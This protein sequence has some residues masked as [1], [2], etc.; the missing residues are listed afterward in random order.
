MHELSIA[1]SFVDGA[2]EELARYPGD[3]VNAVHLKLGKLSGVVKEALLF[4][5]DL[6][7]ER[8]L[9]EGSRLLIEDI[10]PAIFCPHCQT[11]RDASSIQNL[12]CSVCG[13]SSAEIVHGREIMIVGLELENAYETAV[14]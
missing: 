1:M 5:Y 9:L 4:S 11:E 6:A 3:R 2:V 12:V 14:G 7:C 10:E 13:A 8:T